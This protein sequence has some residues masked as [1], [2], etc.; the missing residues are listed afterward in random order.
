M[1][2]NKETN[3]IRKQALND[4]SIRYIQFTVNPYRRA[5]SSYIH[6]A[7][8]KYTGL[9]NNQNM[10]F[11]QFI[12]HLLSGKIK[13]NIH[14]DK[15]LFYLHEKETIQEYHSIN[16]IMEHYGLEPFDFK[17]KYFFQT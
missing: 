11:E 3:A 8:H 2:H 12:Q 7:I 10:S 5:V 13:N 9:N 16:P 17:K 1:K 4:N 14:H 6:V 15:Q